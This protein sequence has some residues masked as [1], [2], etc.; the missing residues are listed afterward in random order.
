MSE[1][2]CGQLVMRWPKSCII[3]PFLLMASGHVTENT[4][5]LKNR[6][7]AV[8]TSYDDLGN[9]TRSFFAE[10]CAKDEPYAMQN[11]SAKI[12]MV[13]RPFQKTQGVALPPP[14]PHPPHE[15]GLRYKGKK[16]M[17]CYHGYRYSQSCLM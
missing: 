4:V 3:S 2:T 6:S 10:S 8:H 9:L 11:F 13:R 17:T 1:V 15:R 12:S 7:E 14:P 16:L 5:S